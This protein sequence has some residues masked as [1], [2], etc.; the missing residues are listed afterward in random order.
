MVY[1]FIG[2]TLVLTFFLIRNAVAESHY[3]SLQKDALYV[4][5]DTRKAYQIRRI[6]FG[7][8]LAFFLAVLLIVIFDGRALR[9][10]RTIEEQAMTLIPPLCLSIGCIL[11]TAVP[12][13]PGKWIVLPE[14]IYIF[15]YDTIIFWKE[16]IGAKLLA[17]KKNTYIT[18]TLVKG[19][20]ESLKQTNYPLL[21]SNEKATDIFHMI[22]D[23]VELEDKLRNQKRIKEQLQA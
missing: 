7:I 17:Q 1:I 9:S 21:V 12:H 4:S 18:V 8:I 23:F 13:T 15:N 6:V 14:G 5:K 2:S 19:E 20:G 22:R 10:A 16:I 11:F 3:Q